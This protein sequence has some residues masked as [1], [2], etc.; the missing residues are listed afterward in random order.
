MRTRLDT[1]GQAPTWRIRLDTGP[2][3]LLHLA[4]L[5]LD[6]KDAAQQ[7]ANRLRHVK[8]KG[9]PLGLA[10]PGA[11]GLPVAFDPSLVRSA[12]PPTRLVLAAPAPT[13]LDRPAI[14]DACLH[15][16]LSFRMVPSCSRLWSALALSTVE[17]R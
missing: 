4:R 1:P 10:A 8:R 16:V 7:F 2:D 14:S 17:L 13:N 6:A 15:L 11:S 5:V 12:L 3:G 9:E